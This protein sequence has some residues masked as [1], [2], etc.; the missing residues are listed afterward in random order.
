[1]HAFHLTDE[2][3]Y[4]DYTYCCN[5]LLGYTGHIASCPCFSELQSKTDLE[6]ELTLFVSSLWREWGWLHV[7]TICLIRQ[8][9]KR[10]RLRRTIVVRFSLCHVLNEWCVRVCVCVCCLLYTSDAADEIHS[11]SLCV[12][13]CVCVCVCVCVSVCVCV[14]VP[15][16]VHACMHVCVC[17]CLRTHVSDTCLCVSMTVCMC[18]CHCVTQFV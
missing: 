4:Q 15:A 11:V 2:P 16:H 10:N 7:V 9:K 1:M 8:N 6:W 14:C 17:V 5:S 3:L 13:M 12:Y 18:L